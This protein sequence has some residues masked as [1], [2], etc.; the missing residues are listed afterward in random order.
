ML[1]RTARP[2]Q[3]SVTQLSH[4]RV[5]RRAARGGR[6]PRRVTQPVPIP[7]GIVSTLSV[8]SSSLKVMPFSTLTWTWTL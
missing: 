4:G 5:T 2:I 3:T 8:Q 1:A 7:R 6:A